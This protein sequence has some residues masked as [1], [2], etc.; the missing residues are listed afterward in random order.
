MLRKPGEEGLGFVLEAIGVGVV[1]PLPVVSSLADG[2]ASHQAGEEP[3]LDARELV[4]GTDHRCGRNQDLEGRVAGE[5]GLLK[6]PLLHGSPHGLVRARRL[7][8]RIPVITPLQKPDLQQIAD[9]VGAV[10]E[11]IFV[12]GRGHGH[13]LAEDRGPQ[14]VGGLDISVR[15]RVVVAIVV[16]VLLPVDR[17]ALEERREPRRSELPVPLGPH[18]LAGLGSPNVR[19]VVVDV[20][21][22]GNEKIR[23]LGADGFECRKSQLLP[24]CGVPEAKGECVHAGHDCEADL[25]CDLPRIQCREG[26]R[27][28]R[29]RLALGVRPGQQPVVVSRA[30]FESGHLGLDDVV[31]IGCGGHP[32]GPKRL[33]EIS[34][35]G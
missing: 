35:R 21:A 6:P 4:V 17:D 1:V 34:L 30:R 13:L 3:A 12:P 25:P 23:V 7:D 16:V 29:F 9:A 28:P 2:R 31:T 11:G 15:V 22:G 14:L 20:V 19:S 32:A 5:E 8:V 33:P 18:A 26:P 24:F 10:C 27:R